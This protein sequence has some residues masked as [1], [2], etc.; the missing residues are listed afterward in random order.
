MRALRVFCDYRKHSIFLNYVSLL[1]R[2]NFPRDSGDTVSRN[3]YLEIIA[4]IQGLRRNPAGY[5]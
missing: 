1:Q 3:A 4:M 5:R 2:L